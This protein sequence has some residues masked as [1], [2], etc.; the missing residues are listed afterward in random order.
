MAQASQQPTAEFQEGHLDVDGLQLRYLEAAPPHPASTVIM[1]DA[2]IW[3]L[4]KL[5]HALAEKYRV[6]ALELP[7]GANASAPTEPQSVKNLAGILNQ[8]VTRVAPE[9]YTLIGT[10]IGANVALWQTLQSPDQVEALVL[11]SPTAILPSSGPAPTS[12]EE[13][14]KR[15]FAHPED[16]QEFSRNTGTVTGERGLVQRIMGTPHAGDAENKLGEILCAALVVFG[17]QDKMVAPEAGG[18]YREKIA[19]S[20][21]SFV[22]D[23]GHIIIAERPEALINAVS[24]FVERRETFVVGRESSIINP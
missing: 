7:G 9:K 8:A 3:G 20:N 12:P 4:S 21:L 15:L 2:M 14:A 1:V 16:I 11:I 18:I 6:V 10:S 19:N 17:L 5:H 22:Y 24:D 23:T 13:V